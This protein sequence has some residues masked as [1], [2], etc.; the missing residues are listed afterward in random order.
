MGLKREMESQGDCKLLWDQKGPER[1]EDPESRIEQKNPH[2]NAESENCS[3]FICHTF[4][5]EAK[6]IP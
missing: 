3:L 6:E 1:T 2:L 4:W 5:E